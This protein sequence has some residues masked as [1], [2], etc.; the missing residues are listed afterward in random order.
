[1]K[2]EFRTI[3]VGEWVNDEVFKLHEDLIYYSELLGTDIIVPKGFETDFASVPRLPFI[4]S[5]FGDRAHHESVIH[6]YLYRTLPHICTREQADKVF[7]EAMTIREKNWFI[8]ES[9][10]I[11]VRFGGKSSWK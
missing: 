8:R 5:L 4:Y 3:L 6:D 7:L 10:F 1:M 11:G 2:S 9:M